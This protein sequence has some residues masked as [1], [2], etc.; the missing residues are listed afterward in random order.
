MKIAILKERALNEKRVAITPD[1]VK[2]LVAHNVEICIEQGAGLTANIT[3]EEYKNAGAKI[4][5]VLLEI[6]ADADIV[7]KVQPSPADNHNELNFIKENALLLGLLSPYSNKDNLKKYVDKK[8]T[9]MAIELLPRITKA[10]GMDVLSSQSNLAG[11]I[12]VIKA[13]NEYGGAFPMMMTAAGTVSPAKLLVMGAGV[14]G[15]QVI[16]TAKRL[17]AIVSAFDVRSV[18]KEQ[19]Q[20]L[21]ASFIEV[22][23]QEDGSTGAGYAK[24]MSEEYKAKQKQLIHETLKKSDIVITT[25]LIPGRSAPILI[26]AEMIKDMKP[27][28]VI[29][30]IAAGSGG[31]C[32]GTIAD[33][34]VMSDNCVKIVGFSNLAAHIPKEASKL[35]SK[36]LYNLLEYLT[37]KEFKQVNLDFEDEITKSCVLTHNGQIIHPNFKEI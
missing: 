19:V 25:A 31:N 18:A 16:A 9:A 10:Q 4:S 6:V 27:G 13:A 2:K 30:D 1:I 21:G 5:N 36:N 35:Y 29:I 3:D 28:S 22:P 24:E 15:L 11:Y 17:G 23:V 32:E 26:T 14:A 7:F 37:N 34:I 20:S 33:E 12:S 8:V